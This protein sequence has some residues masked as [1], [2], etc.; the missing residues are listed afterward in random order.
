VQATHAQQAICDPEFPDVIMLDD[1]TPLDAKAGAA[2]EACNANLSSALQFLIKKHGSCAARLTHS[3]SNV[4]R[5]YR[6]AACCADQASI[7][8]SLAEAPPARFFLFLP[9]MN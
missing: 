1:V 4:S 9:L 3:C 7:M 5:A 6:M 2:L 8:T